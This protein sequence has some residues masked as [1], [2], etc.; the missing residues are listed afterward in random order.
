MYNDLWSL[1]VM[2]LELCLLK[3]VHSSLYKEGKIGYKYLKSSCDRISPRYPVVLGLVKLL[4]SPTPQCRLQI[5]ELDLVRMSSEAAHDSQSPQPTLSSILSGARGSHVLAQ[6]GS[7]KE[8]ARREY[9]GSQPE[10]VERIQRY[11][12]RAPREKPGSS[13]LIQQPSS[14]EFQYTE[15]AEYGIEDTREQKREKQ[16]HSSLELL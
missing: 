12:P 15:G 9:F 3:K 13:N 2:L 4:T 6:R 8:G 11:H 5:Y 16:I 10:D 7:D 1:G 14:H